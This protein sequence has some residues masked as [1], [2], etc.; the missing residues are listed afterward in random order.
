MTGALVNAGAIV[1]GALAGLLLR[2]GVPQAVQK[3]VMQAMGLAV[4][5]IGVRMALE[6]RE[7]LVLIVSLAA[8]TALGEALGIDRRL[9]AFAARLTAATGGRFGDVGTGFITASLIYCLG[10]MGI[11]GALEEGLTGRAAVLLTKAAIDGVTAVL[12][13]ASMG[14]G[15]LL[16]A[17]PVLLYEGAVTLGAAGLAGFFSEAM[18]AEVSGTGGVLVLAIGI[19]LLELADIRIA[20]L[21][22]ALPIA[23]A[24]VSCGL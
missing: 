22:P 11:V 12:F 9:E 16:S 14:A 21:L 8:G 18:L 3:S 7:S 6:S 19:N 1:A 2:G 10:A 24:L 5:V 23:C 17:L 15:V 4:A 20:N 13:A